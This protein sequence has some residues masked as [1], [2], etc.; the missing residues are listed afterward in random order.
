MVW[1]TVTVFF[2]IN[3]LSLASPE[4]FY[5]VAFTVCDILARE[6]TRGSTSSLGLGSEHA[7]RQS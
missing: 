6:M 4:M 7:V 5:M 1:A 3:D 2:R